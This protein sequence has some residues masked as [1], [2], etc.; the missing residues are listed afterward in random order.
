MQQSLQFGIAIPQAFGKKSVDAAL[1]ES[2][3][4]QA[5]VL[6][7]HSLWVQEVID[8]A[9]LD[10]VS[11]L[12]FAA[13]LTRRIRLGSA[14]LLTALRSPLQ[15]AKTLS[16]LDHLSRGRLIVGVGLGSNK[17][18]YSGYGISTDNRLRRFVEGIDLLKALWTEERVSRESEFWKLV[19]ERV[20]PKPVQKP[21]PPL[22]F[23]GSHPNALRRAVR[24]GSGWLGGRT[25]TE[26]FRVQVAGVQQYLGEFKR[27]PA[28][29][30]IGK[31]VYIAV[32]RDKGRAERKLNEWFNQVYRV[33][34]IASSA[35]IYGGEQ[36]CV[37]RLAEIITAGAKLLILNPIADHLE[38]LQALASDV[39]PRIDP[40]WDKAA[41]REFP[42]ATGG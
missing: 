29:F 14:V 12:T 42:V 36:E 24:L 26:K 4:K 15:T 6:G 5:D 2:F 23:G 18:V 22:W 11:L 16:S 20:E 7:Y 33:G 30:M 27:D 34:D 41:E 13:P 37:D 35:A 17:E 1:I 8:A 40:A 21:H 25:S 31:R 10:P 32:D 19:E 3:A 9:L 28:D 38:H 39:L